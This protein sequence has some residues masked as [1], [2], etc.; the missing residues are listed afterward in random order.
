MKNNYFIPFFLSTS[1]LN[2]SYTKE[3][4]PREILPVLEVSFHAYSWSLNWEQIKEL[5]H[6]AHQLPSEAIVSL[7]SCIDAEGDYFRTKRLQSVAY[8]LTTGIHPSLK[9][10]HSFCEDPQQEKPDTVY[11]HAR[12]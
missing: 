8:F 1:C 3:Q 11:V 9:V 10:E 4:T 7:E 12:F 5:R 6:F 2:V